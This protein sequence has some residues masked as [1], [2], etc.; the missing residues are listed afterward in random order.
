MILKHKRLDYCRGVVDKN[1]F[2]FTA[3]S[4][5]RDNGCLVMGAGCAR[6]VRDFY[7]GVD[8]LMGNEIEHL[9]VYGVR[10]VQWNSQY[11]GA[12][13]TKI[14][15]KDK[16]PLD[17]VEFSINQLKQVVQKRPDFTFHLP[18]PAISHGGRSVEDI[19]PMLDVLPDN[20]IVYLDK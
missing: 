17:V 2:M 15:W 10:F 16:S 12:F 1:I 9:S 20:V 8:K 6:Y 5:I 4:V 14:H 3:N 18:C 19:L 7:N 13:Q 11:I